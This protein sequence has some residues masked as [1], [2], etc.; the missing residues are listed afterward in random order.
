MC[1]AIPGKIKKVSGEEAIIDYNGLEKKANISLVDV[2]IN[3]Y[4]IV[5]AGFAIEKLTK[6]DAHKTLNYF[7]NE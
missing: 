3:D 7:Y 1:L 2:K 4:V 5:H 6:K